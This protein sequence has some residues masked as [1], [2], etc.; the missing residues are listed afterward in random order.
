MGINLATTGLLLIMAAWFIQLGYSFKGNNRIQPVFIICYM[1][2]VLA[3]IVSDYIQTSIL[4]HFEAL[5]FIASGVLLVKIL[6][7][8]NGK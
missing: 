6:T 5:T 8:K 1:I 4:S 2:G 3:L 7:G